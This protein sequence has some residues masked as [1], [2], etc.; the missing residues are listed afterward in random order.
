MMEM[1]TTPPP[2]KKRVQI[3][4]G[5]RSARPK[6]E[7]AVRQIA[8]LKVKVNSSDEQLAE[9]RRQQ[10][11]LFGH[12]KRIKMRIVRVNVLSSFESQ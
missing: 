9:N 5:E 4:I 2:P 6:V 10:L 11:L 8:G 1:A 7:L 3:K 12:R